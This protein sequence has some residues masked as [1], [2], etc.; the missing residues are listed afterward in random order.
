MSFLS[1]CTG[2]QQEA[3]ASP[4]TPVMHL[5]MFAC[6]LAQNC[7]NYLHSVTDVA[8]DELSL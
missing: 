6:G 7:N 3:V 5:Y 2:A 8:I 1:S 4:L